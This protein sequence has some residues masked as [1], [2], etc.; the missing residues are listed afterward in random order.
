MAGT[1]AAP[2]QTLP[3]CSVVAVAEPPREVLS[4]TSGITLDLEAATE[5]GFVSP[6][7]DGPPQI[8]ELERGGAL[9]EV[10]PGVARPQVRTPHA[11]A[12]VRGTVYA[13]DVTPTGTSVFV[14]EGEVMV[15]RS[16][17]SDTRV[18]LGAGEGVDVSDDT[19]LIVRQWGAARVQA[20]LARFGR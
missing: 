8:I 11:I 13:L 20:L 18:L 10:A 6:Q 19:P 16:T 2:A 9:I 12:A 7:E 3:G 15:A 4:C 14:I 17:R 5:L 1:G